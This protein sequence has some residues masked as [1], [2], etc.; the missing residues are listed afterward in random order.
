MKPQIF[1]YS[2]S[3]SRSE[4]WRCFRY[5]FPPLPT[6]PINVFSIGRLH[7]TGLPSFQLPERGI[8]ESTSC[9]CWLRTN[10]RRW[11][12]D[13][14]G[15]CQRRKEGI[16]EIRGNSFSWYYTQISAFAAH[17]TDVAFHI[18]RVHMR[19]R[20]WHKNP[21]YILR[22]DRTIQF[23]F[24]IYRYYLWQKIEPIQ[25]RFHPQRTDLVSIVHWWY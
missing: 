12:I 11:V 23:Y 25:P 1:F 13:S 22:Y 4:W 8:S 16:H 3:C 2:Q 10:W 9:C 5:C 6:I 7:S 24:E 17:K 21:H 14:G 20:Q 18:L 15:N 19:Y